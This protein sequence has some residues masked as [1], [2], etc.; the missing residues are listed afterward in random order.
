VNCT[1]KVRAV[2]SFSHFCRESGNKTYR[3]F[4][5]EKDTA[6]AVYSGTVQSGRAG[7]LLSFR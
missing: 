7:G 5:T 3:A 6:D 2:D 1:A 4:M